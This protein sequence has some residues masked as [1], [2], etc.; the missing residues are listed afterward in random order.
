[1]PRQILV[2]GREPA[3]VLSVISA[4]LGLLVTLPTGITVTMATVLVTFIS[5]AFA[6]I[7]AWATRPIAPSVYTGLI[8]AGADVLAAFHYDVSTPTLG[9]V[10]AV[11]LALLMFITRGQVS[12]QIAK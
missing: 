10:N 11:A 6:A 5:A 4:A 12:P 1:M 2:F 9:A 7:T 8:T 3:L